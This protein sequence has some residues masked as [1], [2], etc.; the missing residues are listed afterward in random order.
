MSKSSDSSRLGRGAAMFGVA[1]VA[2]ACTLLQAPVGAATVLTAGDDLA[3]PAAPGAA[4]AKGVR[5]YQLRCWQHG[6][7]LF[8]ESPVTLPAEAARADAK[9]MAHDRNG[10]ALYLT[11]T[12]NATCLVRPA[13]AA[14]GVVMQR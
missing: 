1:L 4:P 10:Q 9:L 8:E 2:I 7:L 12:N 6:R 3:G 14:P 13:A 5:T 11:E